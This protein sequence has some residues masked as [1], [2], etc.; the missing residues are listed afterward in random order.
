VNEQLQV[1]ICHESKM[2]KFDNLVDIARRLTYTDSSRAAAPQAES[3]FRIRCNY[4]HKLGHTINRC[5][6]RQRENDS[7]KK[8]T[9][10]IKTAKCYSYESKYI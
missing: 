9:D 5:H 10:W 6:K 4:C 7:N 8:T 1:A 2:P 3:V